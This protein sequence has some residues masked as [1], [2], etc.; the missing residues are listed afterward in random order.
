MGS[1]GINPV[2][3][4]KVPVV[5]TACASPDIERKVLSVTVQTHSRVYLSRISVVVKNCRATTNLAS[6]RRKREVECVVVNLD[7]SHASLPSAAFSP[8]SVSQG[9]VK[10]VV[11][12]HIPAAPK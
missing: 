2:G 1:T 5:V 10:S 6:G 12:R 11:P 8:V 4:V 3:I 7:R 9:I